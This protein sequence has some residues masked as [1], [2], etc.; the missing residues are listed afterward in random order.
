MLGMQYLVSSRS[1]QNP[2]LR[3]IDASADGGALILHLAD[4]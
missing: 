3:P 2:F 4:N 1:G